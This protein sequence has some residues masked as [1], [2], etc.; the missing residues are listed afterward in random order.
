MLC[1]ELKTDAHLN[2]RNGSLGWETQLSY[3]HREKDGDRLL[4]YITLRVLSGRMYGLL[5]QFFFETFLIAFRKTNS[6]GRE[7]GRGVRFAGTL[8][9]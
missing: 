1:V 6:A 4:P 7:G 3:I 2:W 5:K 8:N 9:I